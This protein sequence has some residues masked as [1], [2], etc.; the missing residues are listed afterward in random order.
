MYVTVVLLYRKYVT[1]ELKVSLLYG[2]PLM[3]MPEHTPS[4]THMQFDEWCNHLQFNI[5]L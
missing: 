3:R 2:K 4:R 1:A 5:K